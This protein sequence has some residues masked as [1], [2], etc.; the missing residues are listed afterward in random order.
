[1]A[2]RPRIL[3]ARALALA[4]TLGAASACGAEGPPPLW[5]EI[6][7]IS[8]GEGTG[9]FA[10]ATL[11]A[12]EPP[13]PHWAPGGCMQWFTIP[14]L[15]AAGPLI[16]RIG[17]LDEQFGHDGYGL[18]VGFDFPQDTL[19][20]GTRIRAIGLG[21]AEYEPFMVET[22]FPPRIESE[23]MPAEDSVVS[24]SSP[25]TVGW[26]PAGSGD[27][28]VNVGVRGSGG[29]VGCYA[30][31]ADGTITVPTELLQYFTSGDSG[32]VYLQRCAT[33]TVPS[34]GL[35]GVHLIACHIPGYHHFNFD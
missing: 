19:A 2:A 20:P 4:G 15:T 30:R 3:T 14:P 21:T 22:A 13:D 34:E 1:M 10:D 31:D 33:A 27:L 6:V 25:L 7:V 16:M 32:T 29:A 35:E 23:Q 17:E 12:G 8:R 28:M 9:G 5:G 24:R 26:S 11:F 18:Y